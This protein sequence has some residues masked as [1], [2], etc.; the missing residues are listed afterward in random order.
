VRSS[1]FTQSEL[2]VEVERRIEHGEDPTQFVRALEKL[3]RSRGSHD[4]YDPSFTPLEVGI[5][6]IGLL[7]ALGFGAVFLAFPPKWW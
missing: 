5:V 7:I 3:A 1:E 2:E 4:G 6:L